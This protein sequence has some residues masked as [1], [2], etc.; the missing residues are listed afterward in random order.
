MAY[1]KH[2]RRVRRRMGAVGTTHRRRRRVSGIGGSITPILIGAAAAVGTKFAMSK[3]LVGANPQ[4]VGGGALVA[5]VL[6]AKFIKGAD[7][8]AI[9]MGIA[10][11]GGITLGQSLGIVSGSDQLMYV[12]GING[13]NRP[14]I[15][16]VGA[17]R[18]I[19]DLNRRAAVSA[20]CMAGALMDDGI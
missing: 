11:A 10:A 14:D 4:L 12:K 6:A 18:N 5:G 8:L 3:L 13:P 16:L 7:G 15:G 17:N 1:R 19:A 20:T 2:H 9:G